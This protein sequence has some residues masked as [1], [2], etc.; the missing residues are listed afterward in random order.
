[1]KPRVAILICNVMVGI[2]VNATVA[3]L[4]YGQ[5]VP[6]IGALLVGLGWRGARI[7]WDRV[8]KRS[9]ASREGK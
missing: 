5:P 7:P 8:V 3:L 6:A 1:M 9:L 4:L 2:H